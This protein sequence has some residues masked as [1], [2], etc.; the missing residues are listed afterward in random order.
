MAAEHLVEDLEAA[1]DAAPNRAITR[2]DVPRALLV[3][4]QIDE[5]IEMALVDWAFILLAW[6]A[7]WF[8]PWWTYP[9][10]ALVVA[11]RLHAFGVIMHDAAHL[12]LRGK[13]L[14]VRFLELIA[15]FP[16][17]TTLNAM[18]YHH[19]RHH[20]DNGMPSDP[21]FKEGVEESRV[22][23]VLQTMR[24]LALMPFWTIR[25]YVGLLTTLFPRLRGFYGR[26]FLQDKS[27]RDLSES[28]EV[29]TCAREDIVQLVV[30]LPILA[31]LLTW[32]VEVGL[33]YAVPATLAGVLAARRL[34]VEHHYVK[35][36]DRRIET[37][38]ATTRD[39]GISRW[40]VDWLL[41]PRNIGYHVVHHI[42]PQ[43]GIRGLPALRDWYV[44][45][46]PTYPPPR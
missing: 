42:H 7:M 28:R 24:G 8:G 26:V 17:A 34:L 6:A 19:L 4:P 3:K 36:A 13:T 22:L 21:Y 29:A 12:P 46:H 43:V 41:A 23:Y 2:A 37:I 38:L 44:A 40:W 14:Q 35:A 25:P 15:A 27:G 20:R 39:H 30:Q 1:L 9:L 33:A 5:L 32:P 10:W 16:L 18:R 11:S 45:N 31:A